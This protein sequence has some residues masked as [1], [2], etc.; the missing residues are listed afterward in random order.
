MTDSPMFKPLL[1][2]ALV[3]GTAPAVAQTFPEAEFGLTL[4]TNFAR[5][6]NFKRAES[7]FVLPLGGALGLQADLAVSK[8]ETAESV[9]PAGGL[10]LTYAASP[11]LTL[12]AFAYGET[13]QDETRVALGLEA[14]VDSG[15]WQVE[16]YA[17]ALQAVNDSAQTGR[18][19]G[20]DI[21]YAA[22]PDWRVTGGAARDD[23]DGRD[24]GF[25][26]LGA[27]YAVTDTIRAGASYGRTDRGDGVLTLQVD[28]VTG[29]V[30][31]GRRDGAAGLPGY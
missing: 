1:A 22:T 2:L 25:V 11:A 16:G 5:E 6:E 3:A 13:V 31:F 4:G 17:A 28:L 27:D 23:F 9:T 29:A 19:Y 12:G 26:H 7:G 20:L 21:A 10:H 15:P 14:A 8:Y 24:R 30:P 18:R